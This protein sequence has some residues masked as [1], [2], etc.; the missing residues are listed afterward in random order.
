MAK[1]IEVIW[2]TPGLYKNR[3]LSQPGIQ[4]D[5]TMKN[6]R[7]KV[8]Q[9]HSSSVQVAVLSFDP[10]VLQPLRMFAQGAFFRRVSDRFRA[11]TIKRNRKDLQRLAAARERPSR[12][13]RLSQFPHSLAQARDEV[14]P[15]R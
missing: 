13:P 3:S 11:T 7:R 8:T 15:E 5:C 9:N 10:G 12:R 4:K 1:V 14:R 6:V 2:Y